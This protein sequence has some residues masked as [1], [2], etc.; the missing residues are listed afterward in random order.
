MRLKE[1]RQKYNLTQAKFA[2]QFRISQQSYNNYENEITQPDIE[3]LKEIAKKYDLSLDFLCDFKSNNNSNLTT[4]QQE[5][6]NLFNQLNE[7]EKK[8]IIAYLK[9]LTN[10]PLTFGD[11][12]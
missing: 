5:L 10:Q 1:I 2:E 4:E 3:L 11:T 7:A 8:N 6:L 9:G 12:K